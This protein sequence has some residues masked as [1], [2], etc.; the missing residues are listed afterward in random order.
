M[1]YYMK[2]TQLQTRTS[3]TELTCHALLNGNIAEKRLAAIA[4]KTKISY[5]VDASCPVPIAVIRD[6]LEDAKT[7]LND[8]GS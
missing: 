4:N 5:R 2:N 8:P 1:S 7:A 3:K 6:E